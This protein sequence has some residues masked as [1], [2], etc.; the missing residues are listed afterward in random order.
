MT[1]EC[2]AVTALVGEILGREAIETA[3]VS[4]LLL[5]LP[6]GCGFAALPRR[7]SERTSLG[8]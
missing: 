7:R 4:R 3:T 6:G 2:F 1:L 5:W 8:E